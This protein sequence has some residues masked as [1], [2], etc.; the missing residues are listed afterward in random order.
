[1]GSSKVEIN[2]RQRRK[3]P[4][5][6]TYEDF[7]A[8]ESSKSSS[9]GGQQSQGDSCCPA[10]RGNQLDWDSLMNVKKKEPWVSMCDLITGVVIAGLVYGVKT[11]I[12]EEEGGM[13][14][15]MMIGV[16]GFAF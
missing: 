12:P 1:M 2:D 8:E 7:K 11:F 16:L 15:S 6:K 3:G 9:G 13:E 4:M 10:P 5:A 14:L